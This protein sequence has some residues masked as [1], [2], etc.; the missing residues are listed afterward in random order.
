MS[1]PAGKLGQWGERQARL[2]LEK[3]GY[4]IVA[5]NFR[6]RAGEIDIIAQNGEEFVFVEVK[7]RRGETYGLAKESISPVK[8]ERLAQVAEEFLQLHYSDEYGS[9][10][11]WRIDLICINL[12]RGGKLTSINHI[13]HAVEF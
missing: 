1:T 2:F 9:A 12:D 7:T 13:D 3:R 4:R 10:T 5:T 8:A 11:E 6:C